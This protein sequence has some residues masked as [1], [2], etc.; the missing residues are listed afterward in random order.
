MHKF[1]KILIEE[2]VLFCGCI[3]DCDHD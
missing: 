1:D 2:I 3:L